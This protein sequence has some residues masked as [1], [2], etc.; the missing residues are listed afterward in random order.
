[1]NR[2]SHDVIEEAEGAQDKAEYATRNAH[3][4]VESP[5]AL[6]VDT[7]V[8]RV[9]LVGRLS[10]HC[11]PEPRVYAD[12]NGGASGAPMD[13]SC[14]VEHRGAYYATAFSVQAGGAYDRQYADVKVVRDWRKVCPP[15]Y[16]DLIRDAVVKVA[17][18]YMESDAGRAAIEQA[19]EHYLSEEHNRLEAAAAGHRAALAV[20]EAALAEKE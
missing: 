12:F 2:S 13:G 9:H 5:N 4:S 20:I 15:T 14:Y 8:G 1:M 18:V 6:R 16:R 19:R 11:D 10:V 7:V 17:T 3:A